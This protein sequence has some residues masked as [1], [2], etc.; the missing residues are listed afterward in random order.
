VKQLKLLKN[1]KSAYGGELLKS[2]KGRASGRPLAV[3]QTMHLVLRSTKARGEWSF[4]RKHNADR[5]A[6]I[7]HKFSQR[8]GVKILSLANVGNH[9][10]FHI[11]L[12]NRYTYAPFIRGVTSAIAMAVTGASRWNKLGVKF[13]DYRP[14]TRVVQGW[15]AVLNLR[16]YIRINQLEGQGYARIEAQFAATWERVAALERAASAHG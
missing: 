4:R 12:S 7:I 5:V 3:R 2:R 6:A 15:R 11:Q 10:H 13:W 1:M 9:L 14:F 16:D 8:Y